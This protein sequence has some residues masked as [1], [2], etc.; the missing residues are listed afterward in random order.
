M[1]HFDLAGVRFSSSK[2]PNPTWIA[3]GTER[4]GALSL[5]GVDHVGATLGEHL[6]RKLPRVLAVDTPLGVPI[7]LARALF[8]LVTNGSQVLEHLVAAGASQLDATWASFAAEHPGALRLTDAIT[9]GAPTVSS[10]RPPVWRQLRA[11]ARMLWPLRDQLSFVPFDALELHPAR[12][13]VIE[14]QPGATLR[15][16]GLPY[17]SYHGV[18]DESATRS[19]AGAE[20]LG[21]VVGLPNALAPLGVRAE[22]AASVADACAADNAGDALD[23][24][25]ACVTAYLATRGLWSPPPISGPYA[26]KVMVEGWIVRPG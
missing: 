7:G 10:P 26:A 21:I 9:H 3:W 4:S 24:T 14:A 23:A 16:L 2:P 6:A 20:R 13:N 8:P 12:A 5:D 17:G 22:I 18:P 25:L 1:E 11:L 15:L 19:P